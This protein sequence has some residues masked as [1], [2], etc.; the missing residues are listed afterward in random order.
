[1]GKIVVIAGPQS[2]GK[3]TAT[4]FLAN[5][6]KDKVKFYDEM[7]QYKLFPEKTKLGGVVVDEEMERA[8][9]EADIKR[10]RKI[11]KE[12][13]KALIETAMFHL[14]Y[15][16]KLIGREFYELA[17]REYREVF[18]GVS[19]KV[20]FID[21]KPEVSFRRRKPVYEA[22]IEREIKEKG[23]VGEAASEFR[24]MM[25][26]KYKR[27]MEE[28]YPG[29]RRVYEEIDYAREKIIIENNERSQE[30]FLAE[31]D[32]EFRRMMEI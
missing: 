32:K 5:K 2:A 9:H 24:K 8:I 4:N 1:M 6:Y 19:L 15:H 27:R 12:E 22:R 25:L 30:D 26:E 28:N 21:T 20:I 18:E 23:W 16:E 11:V 7:N 13:E 10:T 29:W 31:V 14:V 3:T 17:D